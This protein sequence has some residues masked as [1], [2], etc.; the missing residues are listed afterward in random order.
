MNKILLVIDDS[1]GFREAITLAG[2]DHD[3]LVRASNDPEA[4]GA[5]LE[6]YQPDRVLLDWQL[7]GQPRQVYVDLLKEKNLTG[8]TL[9]ISGTMDH[10]REKFIAEHGL[11]GY[12]LKPL[13]L[14]RFNDEISL[15]GEL[16]EN[17]AIP[18]WPGLEIIADQVEVAINILDR[19]LATH[20]SNEKA[21]HKPLTTT[22]RLIVKWLQAEMEDRGYNAARRL[23]WAGEDNC[24]L[25]SRLFQ[26]QNEGYWLARDWR[27]SG[28]Q[29]HD[30]EILNLE[31]N[32]ELKG[33]FEAVARLLAQRYAISRF[34]VYKIAR[35][36]D[37]DGFPVLV[38][39][40]FQSGGGFDPDE[41][42]WR[43]TGFL[44]EQNSLTKA[45][46]EADFQAQPS[47]ANDNQSNKGCEPIRF[48]DNGTYRVLFPVIQ[49]EHGSN[50]TRV[51][52]LFAL[53]RRLDHMSTLTG[54]DKEVVEIATRM[55]S[56][57]AGALTKDQWS[58]MMGL[59]EDL[60]K[61]FIERLDDDEGKRS[62]EWHKTISNAIRNTFAE[63]GRSP[64]MI[65][66]GLTQAC[67]TLV[68]A[69]RDVKKISGRIMGTTPWTLQ[70]QHKHPISSW[71]IALMTDDT[72]WLAVAGWGEAYLACRQ[73]GVHALT[74]P[75]K[76]AKA[77]SAWKAAVIQNFQ[78]WIQHAHEHS[79]HRIG[80]AQL[81]SIGAWLAV[82]MQIDGSMRALMVVHSPHP[83]YFTGFRVT[84]M[85]NTAER[86]LPLLA[87]AQRE[88]RARS[89]F[90]A[91]VM[92]EVKNDSHAA[93][94][95]LE[96][97]Q[98]DAADTPWADRLNEVCFH[99]EG[100]NALGQ[101]TLDIFQLGLDSRIS[102][103]Q[104]YT[105]TRTT[106]LGDLIKK[107]TFGWTTLYEDTK[108]TCK[109]PETLAKIAVSLDLKRVLR[110]L[111]HNAF[112]HGLN[113]VRVEASL[114]EKPEAPAEKWLKISIKN[115]ADE[116]VTR[117]LAEKFN[118]A[119][120]GLG[121]SP[122]IRARLGLAVA[123]QLVTEAGGFL[124]DLEFHATGNN[125]DE[126]AEVTIHLSWSIRPNND[127]VELAP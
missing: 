11:A 15:P 1:P 103:R 114:E 70:N 10:A 24:F 20:W 110:I 84:L 111:L 18:V 83:Y 97:I 33:W 60:G 35:L 58:L 31:K 122:L 29:L 63:A 87:A 104:K 71:Y 43:Q 116:Q 2:E 72:H 16:P 86:L 107:A 55:A 21:R 51:S 95:I 13:D 68:E 48:G 12:R 62:K 7:Q 91:S 106:T 127:N 9:L 67:A 112:R 26:L 105:E 36:P 23:D 88:T 44:A 93:I 28:D 6:N 94:L 85:E 108:F 45:A 118:P 5:W 56:D 41:D 101:D 98:K 25:E 14:E 27:G 54:F 69:W 75:H 117:N 99:L 8:R 124:S 92:H 65:Y 61:R 119:L 82:P 102:K 81:P 22:Q 52:S 42:A 32:Y 74:E 64:E 4:I 126:T 76:T 38:M 120:G 77:T 46:L 59:V 89:A 125:D 53:D 37:I 73:Q 57:D 113:W 123:H 40:L 96:R 80:D 49:P 50:P 30:H 34:R 17:S 79:Y 121:S 115:L 66:E 3:W 90:T 109:I 100:L 39:P 47:F 78:Q 19:N